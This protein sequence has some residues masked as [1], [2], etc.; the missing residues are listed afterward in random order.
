MPKTIPGFRIGHATDTSEPTGCTVIVCPEGAT[1][2]ID[3][4]GAAPGTRETELL[5]PTF[6]I[7]HIHA[8]CLSGGSAYGLRTADGVMNYLLESGIGFQAAGT[9]VPI[10]PAAVIYDLLPGR[11]PLKPTIEMGYRA[12]QGAGDYFE[13]G[14]VGAG[15]GATVGKIL[16]LDRCMRGGLGYASRTLKSGANLAALAV[17]NPFGDVVNPANG[18]IVAGA[19][20]EDGQFADS[21]KHM[22]SVLPFQGYTTNTTLAVLMTDAVFSKEETNRIAAMA[23][24]GIARATRPAHTMFD[25]DICFALSYGKKSADINVIGEMGAQLVSQAIVEAVRVDA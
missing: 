13:T 18:T 2:G 10:V 1:P 4:R 9:I 21:A 11:D 24:N 14:Q 15:C 8:I 23:Q 3:I 5:K 19:R 6:M 16:G 12:A 22:E 20:Q 17:V 25:G 7:R